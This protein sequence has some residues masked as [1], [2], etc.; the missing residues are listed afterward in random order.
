MK[1]RA[2]IFDWAGTLIDHGSRAPVAALQDVFAAAGVPVSVAEA[3]LSMGVA[4]RDHIGAI[5]A[6][7][8]VAQAWELT[9]GTAPLDADRD[10]LYA[11]FIPKQIECL[12]RHSAVIAGVPRAAEE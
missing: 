3:R 8:R 6:L 4:K 11:D 7:P 2:V 1:L 12:E 10:A 5:L 9:Y